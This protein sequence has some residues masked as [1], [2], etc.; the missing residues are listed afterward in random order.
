VSARTTERDEVVCHVI[1]AQAPRYKVVE[2]GRQAPA[3]STGSELYPA[4]FFPLTSSGLNALRRLR[5]RE[6]ILPPIIVNERT[7]G[8]IILKTRTH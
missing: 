2:S 4:E 1:P 7:Q 8:R 5:V 6:R 3:D